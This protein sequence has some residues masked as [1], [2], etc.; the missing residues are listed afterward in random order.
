[1]GSVNEN[2]IM[3]RIPLKPLPYSARELAQCNE[4][5]IDY[6]DEK[7]YHIYI[8]DSKDSTKLIDLTSLIINELFPNATVNAN[9]HLINIEGEVNP[10]SLQTI[11]NY[12]YKRFIMPEDNTGFDI[13]EDLDKLYDNTTQTVLLQD[14]SGVVYLPVTTIDNVY[15][16]TGVNLQD[17]LDSMTRVGFSTGSVT[18]DKEDQTSFHITYPFPGYRDSGNLIEVRLGTVYIENS[19]YQIIDDEAPDENG[20]V[21]GTLVFNEEKIELG[22]SINLLFIYNTAASTGGK[23][24]Y[25]YG[26]LIANGSIPSTKLE[27]ISDSY[28]N[29]DSTS[30]ASSKA[31]YNMYLDIINSINNGNAGTEWFVDVTPNNT[32]FL[33]VANL[34]SSTLYNVLVTN[35]KNNVSIVSLDGEDINLDRPINIKAGSIIKM[36]Y[37]NK[38]F[39]VLKGNNLTTN[40]YIT[41]AKDQDTIVSYRGLQYS[42]GDQIFVYRNGVRLFEDLDYALNSDESINIFVRAEENE[43]FVF[44]SYNIL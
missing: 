24:E 13:N 3:G 1:M 40:R 34:N 22:R 33:K 7:T 9:N 43:T 25:T 28:T 11:V 38:K 14:T 4:I 32:I 16:A 19:R 2:F 27:K 42:T 41:R 20:A 23:F 8:V 29:N 35:D 39:Y 30:V 37:N 21:S 6:D 18:A 26:G 5:L 31:L 15:D 10:I 12:I 44:E 36:I 17:R